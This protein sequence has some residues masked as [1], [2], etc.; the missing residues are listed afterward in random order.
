MP[1]VWS[2]LEPSPI[3]LL[4][5]AIFWTCTVVLILAFRSITRALVVR[6]GWNER[7]VAVI[8]GTK[9]PLRWSNESGA[10]R[11]GASTLWS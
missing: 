3:S 8:G 9:M 10:I 7:P 2:L 4:A 5:T 1:L 6:F 11:N